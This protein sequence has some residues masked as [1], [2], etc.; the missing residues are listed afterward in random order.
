MFFGILDIV[1][2]K[3]PFFYVIML[4]LLLIIIIIISSSILSYCKKSEMVT[5]Q[6][7]GKSKN[8]SNR[9]KLTLK[10]SEN[11]SKAS[12]NPPKRVKITPKEWI[13]LLGG[14]HR[15]TARNKRAVPQWASPKKWNP[16]FWSDFHSLWR[17][18]T[19]FGM[20][21][22]LFEGEFHSIR[23]VFTLSTLEE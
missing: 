1:L 19:R 4:L 17:I 16:L 9:M 2:L 7:R 14:A 11:H 13:S 23:V 22:T 6:K 20:I 5:L 3:Y 21:F 15:E 10:K 18:F 12:E 8:H